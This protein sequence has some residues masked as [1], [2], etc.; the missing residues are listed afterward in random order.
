MCPL[1]SHHQTLEVSLDFT[2][3]EIW[4]LRGGGLGDQGLTAASIG[5]PGLRS[6]QSGWAQDDLM[7]KFP[8][9]QPPVSQ[10]V[11]IYARGPED[12]ISPGFAFQ[13]HWGWLAWEWHGYLFWERCAVAPQLLPQV[14]EEEGIKG[15][16]RVGLC[17]PKWYVEVH[18]ALVLGNLTLFGDRVF[19]DVIKLRWD[20]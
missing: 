8:I 11:I 13:I 9:P 12:R 1:Y 16:L 2:D 17:H 19:A 6:C 3:E 18:S 10:H 7:E 14:L 20:H 4:A 15:Q 5:L